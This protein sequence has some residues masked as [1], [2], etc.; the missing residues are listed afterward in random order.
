L[1]HGE[2]SL[3][4]LDF[5]SA[6]VELIVKINNG[7][8]AVSEL[9]LESMSSLFSGGKVSSKVTVSSSKLLTF[10]SGGLKLGSEVSNG[11]VKVDHLIALGTVN[12]LEA[13]NLG[14]KFS[15]SSSKS[16]VFVSA[17][18]QLRLSF[19]EGVLTSV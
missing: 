12:S 16:L 14:C 18:H 8:L 15:N 11:S 2:S 5:G 7:G 6:S 4:V 3:E 13:L 19:I 17:G 1:T 9:V 10:S